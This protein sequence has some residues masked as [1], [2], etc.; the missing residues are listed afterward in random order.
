MFYSDEAVNDLL[1]Y[2]KFFVDEIA[3]K[4]KK[5]NDFIP[6]QYLIFAGMVSYYG[7]EHVDAIYKVFSKAGFINDSRT[8][9]EFWGK[10][11]L[12]KSYTPAFCEVKIFP[13]SDKF[14]IQRD[15]HHLNCPNEAYGDFFEELV[16]EINHCVNSAISPICKRNSLPVYRIGISIAA[17]HGMYHEAQYLEEAFNTLQSAEIMNHILSFCQYNIEDL[18]MKSVLNR[19]VGRNVHQFG[20]GYES[21][22]PKIYPLYF[23]PEFHQVLKDNRILGNLKTIRNNFDQRVGEGSFFE[24]ASSIDHVWSNRDSEQAGKA[25]QLVSRYVHR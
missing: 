1:R 20:R 3:K 16:H 19:L 4:K 6:E 23:H 12:R 25:Y 9:E 5:S 8:I 21:I 15:I 13:Q 18:S 10:D 11:Y 2:S 24:L 17:I 14:V 22:T 7:F